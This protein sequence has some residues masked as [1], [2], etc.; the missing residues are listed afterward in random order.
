MI[1]EKKEKIAI[2]TERELI[3]LCQTVKKV[4]IECRKLKLKLIDGKAAKAQRNKIADR[5]ESNNI[6]IQGLTENFKSKDA[7]QN[8]E[9]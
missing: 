4:E 8:T 5:G 3:S 7:H 1:L 2:F 9:N 6:L